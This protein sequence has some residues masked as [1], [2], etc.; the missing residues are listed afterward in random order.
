[1]RRTGNDVDLDCWLYT[2]TDENRDESEVVVLTLRLSD[3]TLEVDEIGAAF[4]DVLCLTVRDDEIAV[5]LVLNTDVQLHADA[6]KAARNGIRRRRRGCASRFELFVF[7]TH[8]DT[9]G[10]AA[11]VMQLHSPVHGTKVTLP[12]TSRSIPALKRTVLLS[13]ARHTA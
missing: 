6:V 1:M 11:I 10:N 3:F 8:G 12:V 5:H 7:T 2:D 4:A 13:L 9:R